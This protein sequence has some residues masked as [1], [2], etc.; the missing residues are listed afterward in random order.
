MDCFTS[1]WLEA[2]RREQHVPM[3]HAVGP[4]EGYQ[5]EDGASPAALQPSIPLKRSPLLVQPRIAICSARGTQVPKFRKFQGSRVPQPVLG[6][7]RR[8]R[9]DH[10]KMVEPTALGVLAT[11]ATTQLATTLHLAV[12]SSAVSQAV[13]DR[14]GAEL[15]RLD[16][17]DAASLHSS[18]TS[19]EDMK[20]GK[21]TGMLEAGI[22]ILFRNLK[23]LPELNSKFGKV[24]SR[25][26]SN[27]TR[28]TGRQLR[29]SPRRR[30][31]GARLRAR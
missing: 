10:Q 22:Q 4:S 5:H 19:L 18:L 14:L 25:E 11:W 27:S 12:D 17:D 23:S 6:G 16:G 28:S 31:A 8:E 15:S 7:R 24:R 29:P 9:H 30:C 1:R 20:S 21:L 26:V 3:E 2:A 13:A